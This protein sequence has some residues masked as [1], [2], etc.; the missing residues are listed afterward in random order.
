MT[1][2]L[3]TASQLLTQV[4]VLSAVPRDAWD[5]HDHKIW[6]QAQEFVKNYKERLSASKGKKAGDGAVGESSE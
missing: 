3:D 6:Q 1:D 2:K 4:M 5:Q